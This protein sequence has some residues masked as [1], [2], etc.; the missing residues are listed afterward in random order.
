MATAAQGI[1]RLLVESV[2]DHAILLLDPAGCVKS[3]SLGAEEMTGHFEREA[4]GRPISQLLPR[5]PSAF[6]PGHT[7]ESDWTAEVLR[8]ALAEG[9]YSD[10]GRYLRRDGSEYWATLTLT[11]LLDDTKHVGFALVARDITAR[12]RLEQRLVE[13]QKMDAVSVLA[14]GIAHDFNNLLTVITG[15]ADLLMRS[16]GPTP[17]LRQQVDEILRAGERASLLTQHLLTF[18]RKRVF[19]PR[20]VEFSEV[21]ANIHPLLRTIA[22]DRIRFS[23][24]LA[25]T[26]ARIVADPTELEQVLV[27]LFTNAQQAMPDGGDLTVRTRETLLTDESS[28]EFPESHAGRYVV[29]SVTDTGE[30]IRPEHLSRVFEPFFTTR[31]IG[32]GAG[33]GLASVHGIVRE[34]AGFVT[35]ESEL[36]EG[37]TFHVYL[38]VVEEAATAVSADVPVRRHGSHTVLLVEPEDGVRSVARQA[39]DANGYHVLTASHGLEALALAGSYH[40]PIHVLVTDLLMPGMSGRTLAEFLRQPHP[41]LLVVYT[42]NFAHEGVVARGTLE[43]GEEFLAKPFTS[44][45]MVE[46]VSRLLGRDRGVEPLERRD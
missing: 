13:T 39:L 17:A 6:G 14:G 44:P 34:R 16:L 3:W 41:A 40:G 7:P 27:C 45:S 20:V 38:P 19:E 37:S 11:P 33:L 12:K 21:M 46:S 43:R 18:S 15:Y 26:D 24:R 28:S 32:M 2:R 25:P 4:L 31:P 1:F 8:G 10:E 9:S 42:S 36:G 22:G 30:G 5:R 29:I 35:V 23:M